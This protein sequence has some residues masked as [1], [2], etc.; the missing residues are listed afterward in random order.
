MLPAGLQ[1]RPPVLLEVEHLEAGAGGLAREVR[2]LAPREPV[3]RE[4]V[5]GPHIGLQD[6]EPAGNLEVGQQPHQLAGQGM[7][8]STRAQPGPHVL[9][10]AH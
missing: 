2:G 1:G 10:V 7:P 8:R 9:V 5:V 4:V 3:G 6:L